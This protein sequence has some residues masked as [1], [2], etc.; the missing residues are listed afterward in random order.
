MTLCMLAVYGKQQEGSLQEALLQTL[1]VT[2]P[3][4]GIQY[5]TADWG[6]FCAALCMMV[7]IV[8]FI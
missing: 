1:H 3:C 4:K 8:V 2:L 5:L 6:R 7:T